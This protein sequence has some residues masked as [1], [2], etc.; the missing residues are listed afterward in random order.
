MDF[1]CRL[2]QA[3][4]EC[5][6]VPRLGKGRQVFLARQLDVTSEAV[7]KWLSGEAT[8]R[9]D[10]LRKLAELLGV[11]HVWLA[12]GATTHRDGEEHARSLPSDAMVHAAMSYLILAGYD[13]AVAQSDEQIDI[14]ATMAGEKFAIVVRMG[15]RVA[16]DQ[17]K[18]MFPTAVRADWKAILPG[19]QGSLHLDIYDVPRDTALAYGCHTGNSLECTVRRM[20]NGSLLLGSEEIHPLANPHSH[21]FP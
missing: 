15:E 12:L 9:P 13:V 19:S 20:D 16:P 4:D 14:H 21:L 5:P 7:R 6:V 11:D 18:V 8:P 10:K 2:N 3:C 17:W 1:S